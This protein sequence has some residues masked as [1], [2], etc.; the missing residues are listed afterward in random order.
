[1]FLLK[2]LKYN[3]RDLNTHHYVESHKLVSLS[4]GESLEKSY[5]SDKFNRTLAGSALSPMGF[6]GLSRRSRPADMERKGKKWIDQPHM[7]VIR[8]YET[9]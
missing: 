7:L 6:Q 5:L 2:T 1:M 9:L 3:Y 4:S 8:H